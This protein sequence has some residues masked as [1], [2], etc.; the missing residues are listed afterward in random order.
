ML[1]IISRRLS[2]HLTSQATEGARLLCT[3]ERDPRHVQ[4]KLPGTASQP[5][6]AGGRVHGQEADAREHR[7]A[8][9]ARASLHYRPAL[10]H[11]PLDADCIN[12]K[13]FAT[14]MQGASDKE[15]WQ[16][17]RAAV[18]TSGHTHCL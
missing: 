4:R 18:Y 6:L 8:A 5:H 3:G 12:T 13:S 17:R 2:R 11:R 10:L 1:Q 15:A 7:E 14:C 9:C 16:A